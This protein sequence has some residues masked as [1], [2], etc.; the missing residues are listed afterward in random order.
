MKTTIKLKLKLNFH[1]YLNQ[2]NGIRK[3][4]CYINVIYHYNMMLNEMAMINCKVF[5][6]NRKNIKRCVNTLLI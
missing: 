4:R 6:E 2:Q 5:F 3:G 1:K